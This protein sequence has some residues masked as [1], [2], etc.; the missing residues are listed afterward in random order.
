MKKFD[1]CFDFRLTLAYYILRMA[2]KSAVLSA[3]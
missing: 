3:V 1:E 2:G